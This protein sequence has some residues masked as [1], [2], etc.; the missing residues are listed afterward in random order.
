MVGALKSGFTVE[1]ES[2]MKVTGP[3]T[4]RIDGAPSV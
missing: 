3:S 1:I 2:D 4:C